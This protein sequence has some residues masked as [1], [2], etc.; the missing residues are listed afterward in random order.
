MQEEVYILTGCAGFIGSHLTEALLAQN[1]KVVGIDNFCDFYSPNIKRKN[2]AES[3]KNENFILAEEDIRDVTALRNVFQ[4]HKVKGVIHL[5]AMAGVR[6]SIAKPSLYN[7][8]NISGTMNILELMKEFGVKKFIF[9]SSSSVYGNNKK[10]PFAE[11]D[12]VDKA[13]SPYAATKKAGEVIAHT[14]HHLY[15]ID[16]ALLRF[17]TVYGERQR[18]DL[19][20]HKFT[21]MIANG[22]S[23]PFYGDGSTCRDYTYIDDI[24][25]GI[26]KALTHIERNKDV[27]E[28]LN[29][30]ESETISLQEMVATIEKALNKK[31]KINKLPMQPGDVCQTYADISKAKELIGYS[32]KTDFKEGIEKFV[33]WFKNR[34]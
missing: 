28:I 21:K 27:Y 32:P 24:V 34:E 6:P 20:I 11:T 26:L 16:M 18:P 8:V 17:F 22:E 23:I 33:D 10:V 9:A 13:I 30:G 12:N 1:N 29:L 5:A 3:I 15:N 7:E 14:Y 19:A 31:A 2:I 25:D 4:Q